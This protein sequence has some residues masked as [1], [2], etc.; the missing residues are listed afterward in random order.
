M[1]FNKIECVELPKVNAFTESLTMGTMYTTF[2]LNSTGGVYGCYLEMD[3]RD[4]KYLFF[5]TNT[6]TDD[7][8]LTIKAGN[9]IQST[10]DLVSEALSKNNYIAFMIDSGHFKWVT[11]NKKGST[12]YIDKK[13]TISHGLTN[14]TEKGKVFFTSD[15]STLYIAVFKMPV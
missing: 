7:A 9:S 5:V 10:G 11:P 14:I 8:T 13:Q 15:K 3:E 12:G 6:G 1:G 4:D 2:A